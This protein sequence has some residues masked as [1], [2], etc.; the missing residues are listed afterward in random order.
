MPITYQQ[1][2]K[3]EPQLAALRQSAEALAKEESLRDVACGNRPWYQTRGLKDRLSTMV[4]MDARHPD[5]VVRSSDAYDVVYD[6][7]YRLMPDCRHDG[8]CSMSA[9]PRSQ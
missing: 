9:G 7:L 1:L 4:G 2:A 5:P 6:T 8:S 3:L